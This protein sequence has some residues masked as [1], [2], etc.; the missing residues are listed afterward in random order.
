ML[1]R[2][3]RGWREKARERKVKREMTQKGDKKYA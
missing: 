1:V 2:V 3:V